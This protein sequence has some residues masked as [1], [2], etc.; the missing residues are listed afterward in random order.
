MALAE[1]PDEGWERMAPF[2]VHETHAYGELS[3]ER[4]MTELHATATSFTQFHPL[5]GGV[6][7]ELAWSRQR[8]FEREVLPAFS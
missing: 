3:P 1:D 8:L 5:R 2:F 6:P 7:M 4:F